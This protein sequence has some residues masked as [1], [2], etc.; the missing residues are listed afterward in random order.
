MERNLKLVESPPIVEIKGLHKYFGTTRALD[1]VNFEIPEG[2]IIGLLGPNASGKTTLL[3][4]LAGMCMDYTGE[5]LIDGH[6]PGAFT[7][8]RVAYLPDKSN[9]P[10]DMPV[11]EMINIYKTFF[12]DFDEDKC[13]ELLKV[14]GI[15]ETAT[16]KE[17]SKGVVDKL[18]ISLM[19]AR[20]ARLYLLDEPLGGIDVEA[21]DHVLDIVLENFN[22]K[23]T[24]I[25]VTHLIRDIERLFDTVAVLKEGKITVVEDADVMRTRYGGTLENAMKAYF[26]GEE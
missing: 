4:V 3:K 9:L 15:K 20:K 14:F 12:D 22:P 23:G 21:R 18:Q 11:S 19:M 6:K 10:K 8:A 5:V 13:R 26:R 24:I 2:K 25:I 7:K 16:T 17:M 1:G